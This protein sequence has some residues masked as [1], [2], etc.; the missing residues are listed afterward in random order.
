MYRCSEGLLALALTSILG[1][2]GG[3]APVSNGDSQEG[4]DN[5]NQPMDMPDTP[6]PEDGQLFATIS[7]VG[8]A[9]V[10]VGDM[11]DLEAVSGGAS[12]QVLYTWSTEPA[13]AATLSNATG[14]NTVL[15]V[16]EAVKITVTVQATDVVSGA[17]TSASLGVSPVGAEAPSEAALSIVPV[18]PVEPGDM[19]TLLGSFTG[20][21]PTSLSWAGDPTNA[22]PNELMNFVD[23]NDGTAVFTV[24]DLFTFTDNIGFTLTAE[25][26]D[27]SQLSES[28]TILVQGGP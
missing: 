18:P 26:A 17:S 15:T 13:G 11:V 6:E 7:A 19:V 8:P 5:T 27:E 23:L 24:T 21:T 4:S 9:E 2:A 25:Y 14:E 12:G 10:T 20:P 16:D 28:V 3:P 1:C 22:F